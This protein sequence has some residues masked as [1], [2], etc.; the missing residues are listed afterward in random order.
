M[1]LID[2]ACEQ[3]YLF[4]LIFFLY[5]PNLYIYIKEEFILA[6]SVQCDSLEY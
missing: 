4:E 3:G 2:L 1:E 5:P 6:I